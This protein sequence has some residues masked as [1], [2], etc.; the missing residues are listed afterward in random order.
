MNV[1]SPSL[2][3]ILKPVQPDFWPGKAQRSAEKMQK[4]PIV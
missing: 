2:R 4:G 1:L 3:S